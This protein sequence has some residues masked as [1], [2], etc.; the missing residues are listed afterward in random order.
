MSGPIFA[1]RASPKLPVSQSKRCKLDVSKAVI[2]D[3]ILSANFCRSR[4]A[5]LWR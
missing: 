5:A 1:G 4:L 3:L 2:G